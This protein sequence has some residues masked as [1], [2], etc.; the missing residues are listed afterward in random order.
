[1]RRQ[2]APGK[3]VDEG[4]W[5]A[6]VASAGTFAGWQPGQSPYRNVIP[7]GV[8]KAIG[9]RVHKDDPLRESR[10]RGAHKGGQTIK[11]RGAHL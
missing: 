11:K 5:A 7:E 9:P 4:V 6:H 10:L 2:V 1:M 3:W 8:S